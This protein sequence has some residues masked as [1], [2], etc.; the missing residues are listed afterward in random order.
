MS[1]SVRGNVAQALRFT[2]L[3]VAI[4]FGL[5]S[6]LAT[7]GGGGGGG[8]SVGGGSSSSAGSGT[9]ALLVGDGP[10]DDY[11]HIYVYVTKVS[12]IPAFGTSPGP[13]VLFESSSPAGH[14]IDLL[15]YRDED[16][17]LGIKH[18]VPAGRYE[19][20]RLEVASIEAEGGPCELELVKLPS[21]KIDLNP[22]GG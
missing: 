10:A 8:S 9:V 5:A 15:A 11:D 18:N 19:K 1:A 4:L 17:L 20:I 3:G 21:G 12:L 16:F 2:A 7:G 22:R 14:K 6:I 13:V